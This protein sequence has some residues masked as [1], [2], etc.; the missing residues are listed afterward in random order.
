MKAWID[1]TLQ[2]GYP[3]NVFMQFSA[4]LNAAVNEEDY[5]PNEWLHPGIFDGFVHWYNA[6]KLSLAPWFKVCVIS[7]SPE[8]IR[9]PSSVSGALAVDICPDS[10]LWI[11]QGNEGNNLFKRIKKG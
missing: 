5:S 11:N 10:S 8:L 3:V 1:S 6:C 7:T 4:P 9:N 2:A